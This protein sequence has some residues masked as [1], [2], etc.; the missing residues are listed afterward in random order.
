[1]YFITK[2]E[3]L[4]G[5]TIAYSHMAQFAQKITIGTTDGG[6]FVLE[7]NIDD[8]E[9]EL[10][11]ANK[12]GIL[13]HIFKSDSSRF[14]IKDLTDAGVIT[15]TEFDDFMAKRAEEERIRQERYRKEQAEAEYAKYLQL[16]AKYEPKDG[17]SES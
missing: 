2:Y 3:D 13:N 5:K 17:V 16:K 11:V 7:F 9:V 15:P 14:L 8:D 6:L 1:M 10:S 4:K 12:Y